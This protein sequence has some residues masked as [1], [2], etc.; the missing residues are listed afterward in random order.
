[1]LWVRGAW[2]R[3]FLG[4]A[5]WE[6]MEQRKVRGGELVRQHRASA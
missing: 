3:A 4:G 2:R 6:G 1:M 5:V